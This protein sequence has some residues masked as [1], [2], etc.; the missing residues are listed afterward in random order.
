VRALRDNPSK[1]SSYTAVDISLFSK[2][3]DG[4]LVSLLSQLLV[5]AENLNWRSVG[6]QYWEQTELS[7]E[8]RQLTGTTRANLET[9]LTAFVRTRNDGV[10]GHGLPGGYSPR[11]DVAVV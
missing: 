11:T 2:P 7:T 1:I 6:R 4:S 8:L 5:A 3:A 10:E 9:I